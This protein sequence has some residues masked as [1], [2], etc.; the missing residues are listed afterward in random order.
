MNG[1]LKDWNAIKSCWQKKKKKTA[2]KSG[3]KK[4]T[5]GD[6]HGRSEGVAWFP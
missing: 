5:F 2:I 6:S 4:L 3:E 1:L